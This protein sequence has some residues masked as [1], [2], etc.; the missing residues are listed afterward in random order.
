MEDSNLSRGQA[1][2][3]AKVAI[4][5]HVSLDEDT[6][7]KVETCPDVVVVMFFHAMPKPILGADYDA[8]VI[9]SRASGD[10]IEVKLG[11]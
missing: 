6:Q 8:K 7:V 11:S 5:G 9:I 4:H 2:E 1:I 10:V 3:I